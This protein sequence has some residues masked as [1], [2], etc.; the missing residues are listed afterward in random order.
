MAY[1]SNTGAV[2]MNKELTKILKPNALVLFET[3]KFMLEMRHEQINGF[4]DRLKQ[5][6]V[7]ANLTDLNSKTTTTNKSEDTSKI[8]LEENDYLIFKFQKS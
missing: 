2:N 3:A 7:E 1:F 4:S 5:I 8:K 6:A